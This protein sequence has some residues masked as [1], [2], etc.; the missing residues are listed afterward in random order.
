MYFLRI[1]ILI[2]GTDVVST[3]I[4]SGRGGERGQREKEKKKEGVQAH[5]HINILANKHLLYERGH[6]LLFP[7]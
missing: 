7:P 2:L 3:S 5:R 6:K 1:D 4:F